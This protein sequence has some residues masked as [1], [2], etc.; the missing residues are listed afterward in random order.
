MI[1]LHS[2]ILPG[3]DD[4]AKN[5]EMTLDMLKI[6]AK[7]GTK[8]IVATPHFYR[9]YYLNSYDDIVNLAKEVNNTAKENNIDIEVYPGQEVFLDKKVIEDYKQGVI[10][11]I[12]NSKY[13][14]I[15]LP[16]DRM[17]KET[18]D[19]LYELR[20][21]GIVSVIAHPERYSYIASQPSKINEFIKEGC[22]FQINSGSIKG[23]FGKK[24]QK[25]AETLIK[26]RAC[27]FIASDAHSIGLRSPVIREALD[28]V[29]GIDT[30]L[31]EDII[32]NSDKLL[33]N[34]S[35][36]LKAEKIK[37]KKG[38]FGFLKL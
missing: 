12:G 4:G 20:I 17:P 5:M 11:G 2:H 24:I 25:T 21:Q 16:M 26:H 34:L 10:K 31:Y 32:S 33:Q 15:E 14:L 35:I 9:G 22:L 8:K 18:F 30:E 36:S 19:I 28:T 13:M 1:D 38:I 23:I 27:N 37:D 29:K 7:D 3:I 6:A